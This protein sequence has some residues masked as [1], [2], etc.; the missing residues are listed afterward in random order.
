[1][2]QREEALGRR[3][4]RGAS[5]LSHDVLLLLRCAITCLEQLAAYRR[6]LGAMPLVPG[7]SATGHIIPTW[8]G[9]APRS[10]A[11]AARGGDMGALARA[12][13][14]AGPLAEDDELARGGAAAAEADAAV[15]RARPGRK[16]NVS[17]IRRMSTISGTI[18]P[19]LRGCGYI[20]D[21]T[22]RASARIARL[23]NLHVDELAALA[24]IARERAAR[25][26]S[27]ASAAAAAAAAGGAGG[28]A[29]MPAP[30]P[31]SALEAAAAAAA[32]AEA[33]AAELAICLA[34]FRSFVDENYAKMI[35]IPMSEGCVP[36]L[37]HD[38]AI[39]A[40]TGT[41]PQA[42]CK[43]VARA[44]A[45]AAEAAGADAAGAEAAGSG[46]AAAAAAVAA[47]EAGAEAAAT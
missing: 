13:A 8:A 38:T 25:E 40:L 7:A 23:T 16:Y 10:L 5:D 47:A 21:L 24:A 31:P 29:A 11:A 45:R 9:D 2:G 35:P 15:A 33:D 18:A 41:C 42:D 1:V 14:S 19:R 26:A 27:A 4:A 22:S 6:R 3:R 28:A 17:A 12:A 44:R 39:C 34:G 32:A 30:P 43:N 20:I 37:Y 46:A 36:W